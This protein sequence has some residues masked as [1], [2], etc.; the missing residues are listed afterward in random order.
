MLGAF[1][2]K[3]GEIDAAEEMLTRA[4]QNRRDRKMHFVDQPGAQIVPDGGDAAAKADVL[5]VGGFEGALERVLDAIGDKV[6][7]GAAGHVD[8]W[9]RIVREHEDRNVIGRIVAPPAF[10]GFVRPRP[11]YGP[12]H[13]ASQDPRAE[14]GDAARR[15]VVVGAGRPTL[16]PE[17]HLLKRPSREDP[18]MQRD[19]AHAKWVLE[20]LLGAST[21]AVERQ[22]KALHAQLGH[23]AVLPW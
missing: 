3:P 20:T 18:L 23:G 12:E 19:A 16:F 10:P 2:A 13:V 8:R 4:Q 17:Q 11:A 5:S 21:I 15:Q 22:R 14:I 6:K 9:P 1:E 7:G